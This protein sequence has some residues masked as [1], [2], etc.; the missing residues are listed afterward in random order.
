[1]AVLSSGTVP[2]FLPLVFPL[3][4]YPGLE[5]VVVKGSLLLLAISRMLVAMWVK[6]SGLPGRHVQVH[7]LMLF[8][9][10]ILGTQRQGDGK[11]CA[12][13]PPKERVGVPRNLFP[14]LGV[15]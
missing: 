10:Q 2:L 15:G 5:M 12:P 3:G 14:R 6:G 7:L 1:M 13:L 9:T 4:L 11:D 8:R